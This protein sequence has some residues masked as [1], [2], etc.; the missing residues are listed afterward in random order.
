MAGSLKRIP[1]IVAGSILFAASIA[2]QWSAGQGQEQSGSLEHSQAST[3]MELSGH[4]RCALAATGWIDVTLSSGGRYRASD[5][6]SGSLRYEGRDSGSKGDY[7]IFRI[8][9]GSLSSFAF[10]QWDIGGVDLGNFGWG[11]CDPR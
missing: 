1:L 8:E 10:R 11:Q 3:G 7:S 4:Y 5:G 2:W 9:G 6:S